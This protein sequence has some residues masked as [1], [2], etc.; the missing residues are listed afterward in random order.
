MIFKNIPVISWD[1]YTDLEENE[2]NISHIIQIPNNIMDEC[3]NEHIGKTPIVI[4]IKTLTDEICFGNVEISNDN[5]VVIPHWALHKLNIDVFSTVSLESVELVKIGKIVLK[6]MDS[7]Y[8]Y[9]EKLR[10]QLEEIFSGFL[11]FLG[12]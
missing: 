2:K 12:N 10:E 1:L 5:L 9:W 7:K 4:K 11:C 3:L 8:V 6:A